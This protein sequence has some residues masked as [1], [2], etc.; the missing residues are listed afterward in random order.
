VPALTVSYV[1]PRLKAK[2]RWQIYKI[3]QYHQTKSMKN[4]KN[5][6]KN[7]KRPGKEPF[8]SKALEFEA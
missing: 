4:S 1:P 5:V 8:F 7:V 3:S 6:A 2:Y